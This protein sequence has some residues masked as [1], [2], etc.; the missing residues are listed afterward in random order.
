MRCLLPILIFALTV[1]PCH[2][3]PACGHHVVALLA[4]D[5]LTPADAI[6]DSRELHI[7]RVSGHSGFRQRLRSVPEDQGVGRV[8]NPILHRGVSTTEQRIVCDREAG[9]GR[10][11]QSRRKGQ[12]AGQGV[13]A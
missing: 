6:M 9:E 5:L 11:H 8:F 13:R 4:Y 10:G 3:L 7:A 12:E 2:A 1:H